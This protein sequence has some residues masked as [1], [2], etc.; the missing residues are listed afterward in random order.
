MPK[1]NKK[2]I[3]RPLSLR[4][5]RFTVAKLD[6]ALARAKPQ[7]DLAIEH[8][9]Q[10]GGMPS[11]HVFVLADLSQGSKLIVQDLFGANAM[12]QNGFAGISPAT[13]VA[14]VLRLYEAEAQAK[15]VER[16]LASGQLR[17]LFSAE[18]EV[19]II[20]EDLA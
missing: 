14:R 5:Q 18:G 12:P 17:I 15:Q 2:P 6:E 1:K 11:R 19:T 8:L 7:M 9:Q 4:A 16:P 20:D 10:Q 13:E 3:G